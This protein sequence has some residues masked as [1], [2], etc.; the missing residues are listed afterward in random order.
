M[1]IPPSRN[2]RHLAP[3]IEALA[4]RDPRRAGMLAQRMLAAG[5]LDGQA[6]LVA[7]WALLRWER[8]DHAEQA[9]AAAHE[10]LSASQLGLIARCRRGL[11]M[12]RQLRGEGPSLQEAWEALATCC[13][14]AGQRGE[15]VRSRCEQIAHLN[16]F[17]RY[18][19]AW[20][21]AEEIG[22]ALQRYGAPA[23]HARYQHVKGVAAS[24]R[25]SFAEAQQALDEACACFAQLGQAADVAR[26]RFERSWLWQR[27]EQFDRAEA[28]LDEALAVFQRL[29]MP[30]R[31]AL[32]QR[33]LGVVA[34]YRGDYGRAIALHIAARDLF[35]AAGRSDLAAGCDF[36][37]GTVAHVSGLFDVA[38]GAYRRAQE[39]YSAM[40]NHQYARVAARNQAMVLCTTGLAH[41]ALAI[42]DSLLAQQLDTADLL[43]LAELR[44]A[45][46][47][48]LHSLARAEEAEV[49]LRAAHGLFLGLDTRPAAAECLLD[50]AWLLIEQQN[51]AEAARHLRAAL[52][53]LGGRPA[54]YW[55]ARY[56]L[57]RVAA[58]RGDADL[59][60]G[61]YVAAVDTVAGLRRRLASEHASSQLFVRARQLYHDALL[62]AANRGD[63]GL[64]L[65]LADQQRG[66]VLDQLLRATDVAP[67][68]AETPR[69]AAAAAKLK[70]SLRGEPGAERLDAAL[71]DYVDVL[72]R[73]RHRGRQM[74][75]V[76]ARPDLS[77]VAGRLS[78]AY[79]DDWTV[80]FPIFTDDTLLLAGLT[81]DGPQLAV[82]RFDPALRHLIDR[83]CQPR[84][85]L[86]VYRDIE[87]LENPDLPA[88][89]LLRKLGRRLLPDWLRV[90]LDPRHRLLIVPSGPLYM[91]PWAAL[92]LDDAWLCERAIIEL[93]PALGGGPEAPG[94]IAT[95]PA[96]LVGCADFGGRA[97][98]L[99]AAL[100]SLDVVGRCWPGEVRQLA[101]PAATRETLRTLNQSGELRRYRLIHLA[102]HAQLG[103]AD[104][105]L[106]HIK[107]ADDDL[108]LDEILQL[109]LDDALV[110][111]AACEGGAGKVLPGDEVL[112]L[113]RALLAAGAASVLAN[114]WP[115]ADRG[116]LAILIPFYQA[117]ANG[118]DAATSLARAQRALLAA[119]E[120]DGPDAIL[121]TPFV[122]G[123]FAVTSR[124]SDRD[125]AWPPPSLP[126]S[127]PAIT[128]PL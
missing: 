26:V 77:Q 126:G 16:L 71:G 47:Q 34:R 7:G 112:G 17:G 37:L 12:V 61:H 55:R 32:C 107:L 118:A 68:A 109:R 41:E 24:G 64:V 33:D 115:I 39:H 38:L 52:A 89:D 128:G 123:G 11:L 43:E 84:H 120:G 27:R 42:I 122:W 46:A 9:L 114:L 74:P 63:A 6:L 93:L 91:L 125:L 45:R 81:P 76:E 117:L 95:R 31:V 29:D 40:H 19:E 90:R 82:E 51:Y 87:R 53:D 58:A 15:L 28:D 23:D 79:G 85:R 124:Y 60:L 73:E 67:A 36:N 94:S 99:P 72:F 106:A 104:G 14:E 97:E 48:A 86:L 5:G 103:G 56:G 111:L 98:P 4:D 78:E 2:W 92:R 100:D 119:A 20:A 70:A 101:G 69:G 35:V 59:A 127:S 57:G 96:L 113:G 25:G 80:L 54:H 108:L 62:L 18:A 13:D 75:L 1:A 83:A 65:T 105:L 30:F 116:T 10:Q 50:L 44:A 102:S 8:L 3:Q 121:S 88:W 22:S 49:E 66:L 21:L 110:V